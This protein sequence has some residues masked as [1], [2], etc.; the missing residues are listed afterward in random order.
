M[1]SWPDKKIRS[2]ALWYIRKHCEK[3]AE[4]RFT[5]L[6]TLHEQLIG[7]AILEAEEFPVVSCFVRRGCW[8]V[9]STRRI[10]G[11]NE[12]EFDMSP[13]DV[14]EWRW[15]DFKDAGRSEL[16]EACLIAKDGSSVTVIYETGPASMAPIYYERFWYIK[17]PIL[18]KLSV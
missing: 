5:C 15:G 9:M 12:T 13:L 11:M 14:K 6:D 16:E 8:Y 4:W 1:D 3:E 7:E 18:D 17:Y 2:A 10:L